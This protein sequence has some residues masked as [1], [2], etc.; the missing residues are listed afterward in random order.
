MSYE[1][2][3]ENVLG[4]EIHTNMHGVENVVTKIK[5]ELMGTEVQDDVHKYEQ[6]TSN[7]WIVEKKDTVWYFVSINK[8]INRYKRCLARYGIYVKK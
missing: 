5:C 1:V 6:R 3:F 4:S 2:L 7:W 8:L